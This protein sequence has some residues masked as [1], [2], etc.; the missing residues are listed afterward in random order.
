MPTIAH[1]SHASTL[2]AAFSLLYNLSVTRKCFAV[3]YVAKVL[4]SV[5]IGLRRTY[6]L[7]SLKY[8]HIGLKLIS[9]ELI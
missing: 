3:Q 2:S 9:Q 1:V 5:K 4:I 6:S 8:V 7:I